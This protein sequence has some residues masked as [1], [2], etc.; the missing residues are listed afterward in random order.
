MYHIAKVKLTINGIRNAAYAIIINLRYSLYFHNVII[1]F[2]IF[3]IN[4]FR[5]PIKIFG[6]SLKTKIYHKP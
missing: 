5:E 2:L 6:Y 1:Y 4:Y 3:N